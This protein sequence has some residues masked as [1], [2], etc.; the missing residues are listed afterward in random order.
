MRFLLDSNAVIALLNDP[1]G[2][3]SRRARRHA[4]ADI[5]LSA[6]VAHELYFGAYKSS[7]RERNLAIVDGL[8]FE[9]VPFDREDARHA[10]EIR[11]A[12]ARRG[13]PI[14]AYDVLIAGQ[15]RAR[16]MTLVTRNQREFRR[17]ESLRVENWEAARGSRRGA[18]S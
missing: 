15:A 2:R 18:P 13:A 16:G 7:R 9:I 8:R 1:A 4:P 11:A 5:G 17:V 3:V 10:G 12:L 6:I 14:G